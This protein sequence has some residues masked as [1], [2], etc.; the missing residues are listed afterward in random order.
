MQGSVTESRMPV[1][2]WPGAA[3]QAIGPPRRVQ[4]LEYSAAARGGVHPGA[5]CGSA[6]SA[7]RG[8]AWRRESR[9]RAQPG[10]ATPIWPISSAVS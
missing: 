2:G 10:T 7:P 3:N 9:V 1:N 4:L 8:V 5:N 6:Q